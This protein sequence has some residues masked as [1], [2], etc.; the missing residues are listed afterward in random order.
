MISFIITP[1]INDL[2]FPFSTLTLLVGRQEWHLA[3]KKVGCWFIDWSFGHL[4]APVI[5]TSSITL[6]SNKIQN[7]VIH[8]GRL[9]GGGGVWPNA[10][11]SGQGGG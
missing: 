6:S 10:D 5:T 7:G 4:I 2:S 9:H 1:I 3:C 8:K 11:K